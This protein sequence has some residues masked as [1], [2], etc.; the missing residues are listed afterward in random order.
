MANIETGEFTQKTHCPVPTVGDSS[1]SQRF[2]LD[3]FPIAALEPGR[4]AQPRDG[5]DDQ[6]DAYCLPERVHR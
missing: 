1:P 4:P 3:V 5:V 6:A 2:P